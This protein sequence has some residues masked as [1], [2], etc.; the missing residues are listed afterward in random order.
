MNQTIGTGRFSNAAFWLYSMCL[1][2]AIIVLL[3]VAFS[4]AGQS[5]T[6]DTAPASQVTTIAAIGQDIAKLKA[7]FPQLRE[8]SVSN[9]VLSQR[10]IISYEYHTHIYQ[11]GGSSRSNPWTG[12]RARAWPEPDDDGVWFYI[13]FHDPTSD[14]QIDSQP[15][16]PQ[17][18]F[19]QFLILQGK[20]TNPIADEI[21]KILERHGVKPCPGRTP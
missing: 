2:K 6:P 11:I 15:I 3:C 20:K 7:K 9:N 8:F 17:D 16:D 12:S 4:C 18:C 14:S 10:L 13:D 19:V 21:R 5:G 1:A